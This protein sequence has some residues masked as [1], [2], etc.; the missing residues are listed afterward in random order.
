MS[1][2]DSLFDTKTAAEI[3]S[4][5]VVVVRNSSAR[6]ALAAIE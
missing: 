3:S 6:F 1:E 4:A 5:V 2:L